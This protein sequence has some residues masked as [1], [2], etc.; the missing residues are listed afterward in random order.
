MSSI[1]KKDVKYGKK[2]LLVEDEFDP[3][4][5][6]ERISIM[7][8]MQVVDAFREKAENEGK[9]YQVLIREILKNYIF[10]NKEK[11]IEK[12]LSRVEAAIF[13]RTGT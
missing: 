11:E 3:K 7:L 13:K 12:R 1:R 8:D 4:Y 6:K 2:D 9:K 5:G 10:G